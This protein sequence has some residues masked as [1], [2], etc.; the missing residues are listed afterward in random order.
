MPARGVEKSGCDRSLSALGT[1]NNERRLKGGEEQLAAVVPRE[2][3]YVAEANIGQT[4]RSGGDTGRSDCVRALSTKAR[5]R[6]RHRCP[7]PKMPT[8]RI[9]AGRREGP[10][11]AKGHY[12]K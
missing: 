8:W 7:P 4:S 6:E 9:S 3:D 1:T 11:N 5:D 2:E 12:H 10:R